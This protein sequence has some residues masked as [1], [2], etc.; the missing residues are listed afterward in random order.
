[1]SISR[2]PDSRLGE[3]TAYNE[4]NLED[5]LTAIHTATAFGMNVI[6]TTPLATN[7]PTL[8]PD[9]L[10]SPSNTTADKAKH[11]HHPPT[12]ATPPP[13]AASACP[14]LL[15]AALPAGL[16]HAHEPHCPSAACALSPTTRS[17]CAACPLAW[18]VPAHAAQG[19][20]KS[21]VFI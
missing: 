18:P 15:A 8:T 13:P 19:H 21:A 17:A 1:M 12:H 7:T 11:P 4:N 9:L 10:L 20:R 16:A 3:F 14:H 2:L 5:P 6:L